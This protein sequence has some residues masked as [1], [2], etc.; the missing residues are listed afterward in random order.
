MPT[1]AV[2]I[3]FDMDAFDPTVAPAAANIQPDGTGFFMEEVLAILDG[4]R[5]LEVIGGDVVCIVPTKDN[6]NNIT[7]LNGMVIMHEQIS[8]IADRLK[9]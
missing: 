2:Y 5:G 4:L 8:L 9:G 7:S 6:P 1:A 3:T